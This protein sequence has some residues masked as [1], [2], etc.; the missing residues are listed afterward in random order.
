M[1]KPIPLDPV[2]ELAIIRSRAAS[3]EARQLRL[4]ARLSLSEVADHCGAVTTTV[5]R[6]ESGERRPRGEAGLKYARLIAQLSTLD[7]SPEA[8]S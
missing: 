5:S 2:A 6:W 3:G 7:L 1:K 4:R 8:H